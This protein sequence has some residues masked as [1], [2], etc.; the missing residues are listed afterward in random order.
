MQTYDNIKKYANM[1]G[2]SINEVARRAGIGLNSIYRWRYNQPSVMS[3]NKV[4]KVL[5]VPAYKLLLKD[6]DDTN[7][8]KELL[9]IIEQLPLDEQ[10]TLLN[11]LDALS[12]M[13]KREQANLLRLIKFGLK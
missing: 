11:C 8:N 2:L 5:H 3:L 7:I 6:K 4:A 10:Q 12:E 9:N 13:S 1:R